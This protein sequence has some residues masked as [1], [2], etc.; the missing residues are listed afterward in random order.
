VTRDGV[1]IE[2][3]A[4]VS[5]PDEAAAAA[6]HG[7]DGVGLLRTELLFLGRTTAP[8]EDEQRAAYQQVVDALGGRTVIIR[9]L[10]VGADKTLPYLPMPR[11][12]NPALGLRGIR[13]GLA[14]KELLAEQLRAC[15]RVRPL[16]RVRLMLPMVTD[17][18]DLLGAREVLRLVAAELGVAPPPLGVMVET[19]A[20]ALLADHLAAHADFL[21]LGTN[22]LT[23]YA[24]AMD[25]GNAAVAPRV[26]DLHP[27]VLRLVATAV[28]GATRHGRWVGVCGGMAADRLAV[29]LLVGSGVTELSV[30]PAAVPEVK[31]QVRRLDRAACAALAEEARALPTAA[32]VRTHVR[33]ALERLEQAAA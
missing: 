7:A 11:E 23:Q 13:L 14:R 12:E 22:D 2:V 19:P 27:A 20:A 3:A 25:R 30:G 24:L 5:R 29:P 17:L 26:D 33:A 4:N 16:D 10:D 31:A 32:A 9:T 6:A 15:L 21:S 1:R 18:D 28:D 8:T